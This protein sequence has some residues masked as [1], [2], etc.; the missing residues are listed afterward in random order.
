MTDKDIGLGAAI[1]LV[2]LLW[3]IYI[4][5]SWMLDPF[6]AITGVAIVIMTLVLKGMDTNK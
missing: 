5:R 1:T 4:W 2:F 3:G 6:F